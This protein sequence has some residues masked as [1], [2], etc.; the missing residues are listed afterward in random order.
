M[1]AS[2]RTFIERVM[3]HFRHGRGDYPDS[4]GRFRVQAMVTHLQR[5]LGVRY[6]P[7]RRTESSVLRSEDS[8]LYGILL[9]RG[10]TCGSLPTLYAAV[11]RRLGYPIKLATT[12]GHLFCRWD[13]AERFNIEAAA[14]K[15]VHFYPDEHYRTGRFEMPPQTIAMCGYLQ[16]LTP[17]EEIAGLMCQ[18]AECWMQER[19]Y[20]EAV[21]AY[22]WAHELDPRRWQH[23]FLTKQAMKNWHEALLNR[24]PPYFPRIEVG[25]WERQFTQMPA[26]VELFIVRLRVSESVLNDPELEARW[27]GPLRRNPTERPAG[28]PNVLKVDYRWNQPAAAGSPT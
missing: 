16:T 13:A 26:E 12:K 8:F 10:G 19:N 6:H 24:T 5:D 22:A 27:W 11:G 3:P 23:E 4:E 14:G 20:G 28:F 15:G 18:R 2:C 25:R 17:R 1:A 9:G 7:D 21:T